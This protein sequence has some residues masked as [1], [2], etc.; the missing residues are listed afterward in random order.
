MHKLLLFVALCLTITAQAQQR[1]CHQLIKESHKLNSGSRIGGVPRLVIPVTVPAATEALFYAVQATKK[2]LPP[3]VDL[4]AQILKR[5]RENP[6]KTAANMVQYAASVQ[7]AMGNAPVDVYITDQ[8]GSQLFLNKQPFNAFPDANRMNMTAGTIGVEVEY[9]L[10][11]VTYYICLRNPA[12]V[13][14]IEVSLEVV[15]VGKH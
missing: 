9:S 10:L 7:G 8:Q 6:V 4:A 12:A 5:L 3:F 11:P 1:K 14:S 2:E 15:T 13:E